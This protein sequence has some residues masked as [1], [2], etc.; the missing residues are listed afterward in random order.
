MRGLYRDGNHAQVTDGKHSFPMPRDDYEAKGY[1]PP[2]DKLPTKTE[3]EA[4]NA[5]RA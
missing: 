5:N 3:Y 2:F 4:Q 1:E